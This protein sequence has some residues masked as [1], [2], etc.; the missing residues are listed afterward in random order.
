MTFC[1]AF[2][3]CICFES[4]IHSLER[5]LLRKSGILLYNKIMIVINVLN[6]NISGTFENSKLPNTTQPA[7]HLKTQL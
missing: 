1:I 4:P 3:L 6:I 2:V 5:I 7:E